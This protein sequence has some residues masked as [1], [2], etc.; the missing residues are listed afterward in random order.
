MGKV[1]YYL[2]DQQYQADEAIKYIGSLSDKHQLAWMIRVCKTFKRKPAANLTH[3]Q[4][5]KELFSQRVEHLTKQNEIIDDEIDWFTSIVFDKEIQE[6]INR[7][8]PLIGNPSKWSAFENKI[9][10]KG[11][12]LQSQDAL[13]KRKIN[14]KNLLSF[15][16]DKL[17]QVKALE[18]LYSDLQSICKILIQGNRDENANHTST[19]SDEK[20]IPLEK[21][22]STAKGRIEFIQEIYRDDEITYEEALEKANRLAGK[23]LYSHVDSFHSA[24]NSFIK[25][26]NN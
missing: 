3:I 7:L 17:Y 19:I 26:Q 5:L 9:Y 12:K 2:E 22:L 20:E 6:S 18:Q 23:K 16:S 1:I 13:A 8:E 10:R 4:L 21:K 15:W 11:Q 25:R 14:Q 24:R